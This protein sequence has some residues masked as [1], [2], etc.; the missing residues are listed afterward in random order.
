MLIDMF[1][2]IAGFG[3][4]TSPE[5]SLATLL[6]TD[7]VA[8]TATAARLGDA[9][10]RQLLAAHNRGVRTALADHHGHEINTTGDGFLAT[11][12]TPAAALRA[13]V[14]IRD[15]VTALGLEVRI[16]VHTGEIEIMPDDIGGIAVHAVARLMALGG[17][18]EV[19]VS[20]TTRSLTAGARFAF[21]FSDRGLHELKG[22]EDPMHA[23]TLIA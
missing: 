8:S 2:N 12:A 9:A 11:F 16:G 21:T 14:A 4:P 7:I 17:A 6:M 19:M 15:V 3:L 5:R 23:W 18:S 20:D 10:W 1:G 22:L 13:A